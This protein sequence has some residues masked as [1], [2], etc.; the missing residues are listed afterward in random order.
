MLPTLPIWITL[1]FVLI[2]LATIICFVLALKSRG[3]LIGVLLCA[4]LQ[5]ALGLSG[6][7]TDSSSIPPRVFAFGVLPTL[8]FIAA[9]VLN[10]SGR[11]LM[12]RSDLRTLTW[13]HVIRVPVEI[14]LYC[15]VNIAL[16]SKYMSVHGTNFDVL[17]GLSA[18]V[19]AYI[20]FRNGSVNKRLLLV[21]NVLT[22][23]LLLNVVITAAFCIP[24]P[25]QQLAFDQPNIAVLYFP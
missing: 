16:L 8:I 15:L 6:F 22:L 1:L 19:I 12:D 23:M 7:Y 11:A 10:K 5:A 20:A 24:S 18:P 17:S 25:I 14:V 13:M 21:W 4:G 9:C 3:M 2:T